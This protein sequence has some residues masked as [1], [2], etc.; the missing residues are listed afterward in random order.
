MKRIGKETLLQQDEFI[1]PE[2][3][4]SLYSPIVPMVEKDNER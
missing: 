2:F 1:L 3:S 4:F